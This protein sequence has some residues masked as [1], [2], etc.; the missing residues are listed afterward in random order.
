MYYINLCTC[1]RDTDLQSDVS[2]VRSREQHTAIS[3]N[4]VK[5]LN[6]PRYY[7]STHTSS[8]KS[9]DPV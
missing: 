3:A 4:P 1:L 9:V 2:L 5:I 6:K 7:R 8:D